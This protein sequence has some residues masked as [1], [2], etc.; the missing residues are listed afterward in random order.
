M[1]KIKK[2]LSKVP[3]YLKYLCTFIEVIKEVKKLI[4]YIF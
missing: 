2:I 4:N 1:K 3:N